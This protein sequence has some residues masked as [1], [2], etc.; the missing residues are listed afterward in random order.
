[1]LSSALEADDQRVSPLARA[2]LD[3]ALAGEHDGPDAQETLSHP[4]QLGQLGTALG[5]VEEEHGPARVQR[6]NQQQEL[7]LAGSLGL[8]PVL[9][10]RVG[11]SLGDGIEDGFQTGR[12]AQPQHGAPLEA[13][14]H[15]QRQ[16]G[17]ADPAR[18][19][20]EHQ[21]LA[22]QLAEDPLLLRLAA[23]EDGHPA[24]E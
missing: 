14:G 13:M 23:D 18:T 22:P 3:A 20:Q 24:G 21:V 16:R 1:M 15:L 4:Q 5:T 9:A 17:L 11:Q 6:L 12:L 19:F 7:V 8:E 10:K 2:E